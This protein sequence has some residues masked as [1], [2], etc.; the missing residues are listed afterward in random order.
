MSKIIST[1]QAYCIADLRSDSGDQD[2]AD[3]INFCAGTADM[4]TRALK[5]L[6]WAC[7]EKNGAKRR[8]ALQTVLM[9]LEAQGESLAAF[10]SR[11][12]VSA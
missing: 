7:T 9:E 1:A 2:A 3:A 11:E 8:N 6:A 10:P 12:T 4:R 5:K